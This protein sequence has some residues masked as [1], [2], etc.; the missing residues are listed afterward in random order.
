MPKGLEFVKYN[1]SYFN[2]IGL[3]RD[4]EVTKKKRVL[5]NIDN[6]NYFSTESFSS[7]KWP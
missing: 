5:L 6:A 4:D 1:D 3:I 2:S 7:N